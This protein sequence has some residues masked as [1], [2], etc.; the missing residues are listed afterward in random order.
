MLRIETPIIL[1][2]VVL[3]LQIV[4]SKMLRDYAQIQNALNKVIGP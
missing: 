1:M 2:I 4:A 3:G